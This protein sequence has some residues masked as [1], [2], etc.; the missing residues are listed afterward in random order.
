MTIEYPLHIKNI[1]YIKMEPMCI[2]SKF[3]KQI[4]IEK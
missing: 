1:I 3:M 2:I 4:E